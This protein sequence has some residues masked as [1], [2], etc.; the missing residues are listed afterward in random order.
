[1]TVKVKVWDLPLR[2]FHWALV[3]AVGFAVVTGEI[4]GSWADWH[5]RFGLIVLGLLF[6][7]L[8]W[9]FIGSNHARFASFV[10]T[11]ARI[12]AY[13]QGGWEGIGHNPLG[14]LAVLALLGLAG[15]QV[16][17]GLFANDD[18]AFQGPLAG[19]VD[20]P[21]SDKL[22][23]LHATAFYVLAA[24]IGLHVAAIVFYVRVKK[25]NLVK[26][27]L[28]GTKQVPRELAVPAT[29]HS[30]GR[31]AVAAIA[32]GVLVWTITDGLP[33]RLTKALDVQASVAG[34]AW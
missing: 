20:K 34:P 27:M 33:D 29:G 7:R 6:F 10:P 25:H 16:G 14:A 17:T 31:F 12:A 9:G 30:L 13:L 5:G 11:P 15:L 4:G 3:L 21:V 19:L 23:G 1:M 26:P 28:T 32:A 18:I 2:L 24:L 8:I 22:T